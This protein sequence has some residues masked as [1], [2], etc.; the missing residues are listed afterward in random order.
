MNNVDPLQYSVFKWI[1]DY[2]D[3]KVKVSTQGRRSICPTLHCRSIL[4]NKETTST[5][6]R[7]INLVVGGIGSNM[8]KRAQTTRV[9]FEMILNGM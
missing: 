4:E 6:P 3:L 2:S 5:H 8:N 7:D 1:P 9:A